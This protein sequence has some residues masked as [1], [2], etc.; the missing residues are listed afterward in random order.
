MPTFSNVVMLLKVGKIYNG[1]LWESFLSFDELSSNLT[2]QYDHFAPNIEASLSWIGQKMMK[3]SQKLGYQQFVNQTVQ[4]MHMQ[5]L[6]VVQWYIELSM[7]CDSLL[8]IVLWRWSISN[9]DNYCDSFV[10]LSIVSIVFQYLNTFIWLLSNLSRKLWDCFK[11]S[12]IIRK[13]TV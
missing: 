4:I 7:Y 10:W 2:T 11:A 8:P 6:L 5:F 3:L 12:S 9:G 1:G 13:E